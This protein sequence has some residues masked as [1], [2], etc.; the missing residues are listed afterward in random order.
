[1]AA[2]SDKRPTIGDGGLEAGLDV[3]STEPVAEP[4]LSTRWRKRLL[5]PLVALVLVVV[6]WQ[7]VVLAGVQPR[8]VLPSPLDVWY[9][10]KERIADGSLPTAVL[11]SIE[12]GGVGFVAAVLI[13]TP[14]GLLVARVRPVRTAVGPLISGLQV[15]PSVAW[16]PAAILWFGLSDATAYFVILMGA[17][18]SI[19]N[20]LVSGVDQVPPL[21]P[22]VG[23]VLGAS[24]WALVRHVILPAALP[25]YLA[26]LRQGWAF[27]WRSLMAAEIIA[28]GGEMGFGLGALLQQGR[29][30]S[31]MQVVMVA[32]LAILAVGIAVEL[33]VFAPIE[34]GVLA[35]R[36]L[37][38]A[39]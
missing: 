6:V 26:G 37:A 23:A 35:R 27:S 15:L 32:I 12:R 16:V 39:S 22:R 25:G 3:L 19:I 5:P 33:C 4:G 13:G 1:M 38:R 11:T 34:R 18:P 8:Y 17:V 7:L 2:T 9:T 20:G 10:I 31:D 14:L 29:D 30:L 36:G 28:I 24:R 21:F